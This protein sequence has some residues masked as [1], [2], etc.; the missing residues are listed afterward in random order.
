MLCQAAK[1][2]CDTGQN[3]TYFHLS[4]LLESTETVPRL[5]TELEKRRDA[6]PVRHITVGVTYVVS[7]LTI[8]FHFFEI[9]PTF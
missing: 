9:D 3:E 6:L 5:R 4:Q 8:L 2:S 1:T 7:L